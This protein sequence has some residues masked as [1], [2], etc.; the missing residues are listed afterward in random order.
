M[1][2]LFENNLYE[3][4]LM[5]D[6]VV[7]PPVVVEASDAEDATL[8]AASLHPVGSTVHYLSINVILEQK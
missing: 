5:V 6:K 2:S 1:A 8:F 3:V 4:R 7:Q